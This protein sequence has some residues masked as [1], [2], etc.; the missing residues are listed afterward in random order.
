VYRRLEREGVLL[1]DETGQPAM[2]RWWNGVSALLDFTH[3][4]AVDWFQS[5]L[6]YLTE[7]YGVDGF[8]LD[9]GDAEYYP[10]MIASE[11]VSPNTHT[12]LYG[13]LGLKYPLNEYRAMW[14]MG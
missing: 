14:K 6:D 8:K 3:P 5:Q 4:G 10:G 1:K 9:G 11:P 2:S 7:T 12:Q 13:R